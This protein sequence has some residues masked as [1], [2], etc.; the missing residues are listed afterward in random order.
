MTEI[1]IWRHAEAEVKSESGLDS[2]RA[3]TRKGREDAHNMAK[4]LNKHLPAD[5]KVYCSPAL[6]CKQTVEAL[7]KLSKKKRQWNVQY[8]EVLS[9][10]SHAHSIRQQLILANSTALLLVG[11][12]PILGELVGDLLHKNHTQIRYTEPSSLGIDDIS[13]ILHLNKGNEDSNVQHVIKKGAVWWLRHRNQ[14]HVAVPKGLG[15]SEEMHVLTVQ[16]PR[17]L[18]IT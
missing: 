1:I 2:E 10:E 8:T 12:Q 4:W 15:L 17:F 18:P 11:H 16:H 14:P 13:S 3:L 5:T 7:T 9:L 6:R